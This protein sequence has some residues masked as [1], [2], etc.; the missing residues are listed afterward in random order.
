[1]EM[2]NRTVRGLIVSMMLASVVSAAQKQEVI[3]LAEGKITLNVPQ[4]WTRQPP[5]SRMI[6]HEFSAPAPNDKLAAGRL[7]VMRAGGS[8]KANIDRWLGQFTQP[9]GRPT[10]EVAKVSEKKVDG[11]VI[12]FVDVSGTFSDQAGPFAPAVKREGYRMLGLIIPREKNGQ[13]FVKFYGPKETMESHEK[14]FQK[15]IDSLQVKP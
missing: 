5:R 14:E 4:K 1:M 10:K 2:I 8:V 12:H 7:T 9:D 6:E 3:T 11:Q 15:M 13:Y